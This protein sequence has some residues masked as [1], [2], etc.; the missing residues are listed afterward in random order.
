MHERR[1]HDDR[2][3]DD[4]DKASTLAKPDRE[5][6]KKD[7][8]LLIKHAEAVKDHTSDGKRR[9]PKCGYSSNK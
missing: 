7:V 2:F 1:E 5:A 6:A 8:E 9:Q 4:L 3:K